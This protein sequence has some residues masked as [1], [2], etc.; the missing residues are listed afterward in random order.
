MIHV[1]FTSNYDAFCFFLFY[2][3]VMWLKIHK[4]VFTAREHPPLTPW[5]TLQFSDDF[6]PRWYLNWHCNIRS[7]TSHKQLKISTNNH[8]NAYLLLSN[9]SC[10]ISGQQ[11]VME[12]HFDWLLCKIL[13]SHDMWWYV[14][15]MMH[16]I[17]KYWFLQ[18]HNQL[19]LY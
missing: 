19:L 7:I 5:E 1:Y 3:N 18:H 13:Y 6:Y 12:H 10:G 9:Q 16:I 17:N 14:P 4:N 8:Y 11:R 15:V 2:F